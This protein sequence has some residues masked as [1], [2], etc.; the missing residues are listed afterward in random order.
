M[1]YFFEKLFSRDCLVFFFSIFFFLFKKKFRKLFYFLIFN[2]RTKTRKCAWKTMIRVDGIQRHKV[3]NLK[4]CGND[5][6]RR[7][8]RHEHLSLQRQRKIFIFFNLFFAFLVDNTG[9]YIRPKPP[10]TVYF[11]TP[12]P[13]PARA[14]I[15]CG[16]HRTCEACNAATTGG[17]G[18]CGWC[19]RE[20]VASSSTR[21]RLCPDANC[22]LLLRA[23]Q[24][25]SF[26]AAA[27]PNRGLSLTAGCAA[28]ASCRACED[29]ALRCQWSDGKCR[30]KSNGVV[31]QPFGAPCL[32]DLAKPPVNC[33]SF[34]NDCRQCQMHNECVY[35][36]V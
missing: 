26:V 8:R 5:S 22:A 19:Q 23:T 30:S 33:A 34:T 21:L 24:Q 13:T 18:G 32:G 35:W 15:G 9:T 25:R 16:V 27:F 14:A 3:V 2:S 6:R 7:R 36:F 17:A 12:K 29:S 28:I 31:R 20:C 11:V 10:S 1:I 4:M